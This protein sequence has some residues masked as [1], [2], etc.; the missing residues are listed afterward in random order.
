MRETSSSII[1]NTSFAATK[2][3]LGEHNEKTTDILGISAVIINDLKQRRQ[4]DYDFDW[5][6]ALQVK[7]SSMAICYKHMN[8]LTPVFTLCSFRTT[9]KYS[10]WFLHIFCSTQP[11]HTGRSCLSILMFQLLQI[12]Y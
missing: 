4:K 5:N 2:A 9:G 12:Q 7:S 3:L 11:E 8:I 1:L 10:Q 6:R